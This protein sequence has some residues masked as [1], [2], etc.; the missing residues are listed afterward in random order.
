M[1]YYDKKSKKDNILFFY[2]LNVSIGCGP[3]YLY[4]AVHLSRGGQNSLQIVPKQNS[5]DWSAKTEP[6]FL[7]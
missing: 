6:I 2:R 5:M 1:H 4:S 3:K 7:W